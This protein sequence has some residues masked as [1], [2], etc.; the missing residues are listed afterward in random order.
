MTAEEM[1]E[2]LLLKYKGDEE[3]VYLKG[4]LEYWY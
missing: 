4:H 3:L 2:T 1:I